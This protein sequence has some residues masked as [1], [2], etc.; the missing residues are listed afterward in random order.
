MERPQNWE[1]GGLNAGLL[2]SALWGLRQVT[3]PAFTHLPRSDSP[4]VKVAS[5]S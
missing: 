4:F 3:A 2:D 1:G 5:L